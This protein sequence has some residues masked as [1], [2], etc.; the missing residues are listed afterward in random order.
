[1]RRL[2]EEE[3]D[4]LPPIGPLT[5]LPF[6][7]SPLSGLSAGGRGTQ[8]CGHPPLI[9]QI[10]RGSL[11]RVQVADGAGSSS[12]VAESTTATGGERIMT[13]AVAGASQSPLLPFKR[14]S[15]PRRSGTFEPPPLLHQSRSNSGGQ[16][17][18]ARSASGGVL[19]GRSDSD[20]P[21]LHCLRIRLVVACSHAARTALLMPSKRGFRWKYNTSWEV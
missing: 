19:R 9:R 7:D 6:V 16:Q 13:D 8:L 12:A 4:I 17:L 14:P 3:D 20:S 5:A 11:Q 1:M 21:V 15:G 18:R 10:S 2:R